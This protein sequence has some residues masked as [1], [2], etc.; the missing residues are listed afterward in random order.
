MSQTSAFQ[1]DVPRGFPSL[2]KLK[3]ALNSS[4][5]PSLDGLR[6]VSV[7]LVILT[8]L[9]VPHIPDIH[10]V[11]TF[12]VLSGFL[13]TWL[14][15]KESSRTGDV[16]LKKFYARRALR[17]FPAFYVFWFLHFGLHLASR[18]FPPHRVLFDYLSAF[19]YVSDY[20]F[21]ITHIRPVLAHTWS[22]SVE[23]QFY[24]IWP[25]VFLFFQ[26]D[27]RKLTGILVGIIAF[28]YVYRV[29][30]F[31]F[32]NVSD[33]YLHSAFD[34]R[35]DHLF[36]GCLL[37]VLLK[38]GVLQDFWATVTRSM[39]APAI[40]LLILIASIALNEHFHYRYKY[41]VGFTLDPFLI[42]I[43][44]VQMVALGDTV[45][46][47]WLNWPVIRYVGRVS[48]PMYLYHGLADDAAM[49]ILK[50]KSLWLVAPAAVLIATCF[51][52]ASYFV[53][54]KPFLRL[55]SKFSPPETL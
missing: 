33:D 53:V 2:E 1:P 35:A 42:T 45:L 21:P 51:A 20:R 26:K 28:V 30:L 13:I 3:R 40:T 22:L 9:H 27:L 34:S 39:A 8:H 6:A 43:F 32:L 4:N 14:L 12:F 38:R 37:A 49:H 24:L 15:L 48:Y 5:I 46:W 44:L 11:L 31:F 19:F 54:E 23:E 25:C 52:S 17:I 18:G 10:G 47:R 29:V 36:F 7:V 50:G 16:S 55:K 41:L